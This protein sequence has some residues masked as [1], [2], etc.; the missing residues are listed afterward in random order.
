MVYWTLIAFEVVLSFFQDCQSKIEEHSTPPETFRDKFNN[1]PKPKRQDGNEW[2]VGESLS[3]KI[4]LKVVRKTAED[5]QR[6]Y[7]QMLKAVELVLEC[8]RITK[9]HIALLTSFLNILIQEAIHSGESTKLQHDNNGKLRDPQT[10]TKF[11]TCLMWT[12]CTGIW[13]DNQLPATFVMVVEG[14]DGA[15][16]QHTAGLD[17][18]AALNLI[19]K[20]KADE[21]G[22]HLKLYQKPCVMT[23]I[24]T[25]VR[26]LHWV[27][28]TYCVSNRADWY[29]AKFAVLEDKD[30]DGFDILLSRKEIEKRSFYIRNRAALFFQAS[31]EGKILR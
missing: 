10:S 8:W 9:K 5:H 24:G 6:H 19:S 16:Q 15:T 2:K 25:T 22:L 14:D 31:G 27:K 11:K 13:T 23:A 17:S 28:L 29:T 21:L 18:G 7:T 12:V 26:A 1:V 3:C 30:C 4:V 20:R